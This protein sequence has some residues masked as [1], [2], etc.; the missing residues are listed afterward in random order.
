MYEYRHYG[1]DL[2][3]LLP[4]LSFVIISHI[5]TYTHILTYADRWHVLMKAMLVCH[6]FPS[7]ISYQVPF[8]Y[9][10]YESNANLWPGVHRAYELVDRYQLVNSYGLFRRMTGVSGRPE[11]VIEGSNDGVTWTVS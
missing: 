9:V 5:S 2:K 10:E 11:V 7:V 3:A 4:S 1:A 8:T 6:H